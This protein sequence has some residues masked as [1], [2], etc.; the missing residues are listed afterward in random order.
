MDLCVCILFCTKR[1]K[2]KDAGVVC[3]ETVTALT[4]TPA[5]PPSRSA[6]LRLSENPFCFEMS[7]SLSSEMRTETFFAW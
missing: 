2:K 1:L 5:W 4:D 6:F 7:T 3:Y